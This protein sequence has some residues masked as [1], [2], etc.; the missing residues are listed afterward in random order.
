MQTQKYT[1][2]QIIYRR[3]SE[4]TPNPQNAR[5]HPKQQIRQIAASIKQFGFVVPILIDRNNRIIAGHAR[6]E[7]AK[8]LDIQE[9]PT[10]LLEN[11]SE[12]QI[13][14]F[15][16]ADNRLAEKAVWDP[17]TLA[18][19]LQHLVEVDEFDVSVTGFEVAEIDSIIEEARSGSEENDAIE[20]DETA[21]PITRLGDLWKLGRHRLFCGDALQESSFAKLM[22]ARRADLVFLDCPYNVRIDGNVCGK[23]SIHH[24]EFAMASGEM[25][26]A[27]FMAFLTTALRLL[28]RL[29]VVLQCISSAWTG[30]TLGSYLLLAIKSIRNC[31]TCAFG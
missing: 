3:L 6:A 21:M 18:V 15:M 2:A 19:E 14:A 10:I 29:A 23:G 16:L 30:G 8:L 1:K 13:K 11:L 4:L 31:L 26:A 5:K 24:R 25:S 12:N 9:I 22:A 7:A 28:S 17:E 27:E 20:M